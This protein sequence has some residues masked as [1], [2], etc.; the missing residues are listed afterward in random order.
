MFGVRIPSFLLKDRI[1]ISRFAGSGG[2]GDSWAA[3]VVGVKAHIEPRRRLVATA[4]G[5]AT[6]MADATCYIRPENP[7]VPVGS[8]VLWGGVQYTVLAAGAVPS[9]ERPSFRELIL[10]RGAQ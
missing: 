1:D 7:P 10:G 4:G 2:E 8:I 6:T 5:E 3:P 9:E